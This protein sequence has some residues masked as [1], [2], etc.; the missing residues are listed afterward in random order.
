MFAI[1]RSY[2][3]KEARKAADAWLEAWYQIEL[4]SSPAVYGSRTIYTVRALNAP[5][6]HLSPGELGTYLP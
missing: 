1:H 4:T 3:K 5:S 2:S 6:P